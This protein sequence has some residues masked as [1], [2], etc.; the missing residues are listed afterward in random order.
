M[1]ISSRNGITLKVIP[2]RLPLVYILKCAPTI[3][4]IN[5][6]LIIY[7]Q[8]LNF[9]NEQVRKAVLDNVRFWLDLGVDGFRFAQLM[10]HLAHFANLRVTPS[11]AGH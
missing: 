7:G 2:L 10:N 5:I 4:F 6:A 1:T 3:Y 11:P 8:C 9:H